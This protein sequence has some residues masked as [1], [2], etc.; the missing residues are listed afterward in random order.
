MPM[1]ERYGQGQY[2]DGT[3]GFDILLIEN[4]G[5]LVK[6][7]R[8][9]FRDWRVVGAPS[10]KEAVRV[11]HE[12]GNG[13]DCIILDL[14]LD[15]SEGQA[16]LDKI[17]FYSQAPVVVWT[18]S[19]LAGDFRKRILELG[20]YGV[21]PKGDFNRELIEAVVERAIYKRREE[22][23]NTTAMRLNAILD[24]FHARRR[25]FLGQAGI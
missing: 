23:K 12:N 3:D 18:G 6:A 15:D 11:L 10:V 4:D 8:E 7:A 21:I 22:R 2:L 5:A 24:K 17:S 20:L 13:F 9:S 14:G 25:E 16:T 19:D 1:A